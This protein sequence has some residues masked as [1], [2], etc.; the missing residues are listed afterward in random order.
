MAVT[1]IKALA[2]RYTFLGQA[3]QY[4]GVKFVVPEGR[5]NYRCLLC[6]TSG[7]QQRTAHRH[8]GSLNHRTRHAVILQCQQQEY[9]ERIAVKF[10]KNCNAL[11]LP[12]IQ[13]APWRRKMKSILFDLLM[14]LKSFC[15]C[16]LFFAK[17]LRMEAL[18]LLELALWK[19]KI[20]NGITFSSIQDMREYPTLDIDFNVQRF[21]Y[22]MRVSSGAQVV[23]PL[24]L[25]YLGPVKV[26][27]IPYNIR[28]NFHRRREFEGVAANP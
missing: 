6:A 28:T 25:E 10:M 12:L 15:E 20:A 4:R 16:E 14:G 18:S 1:S 19:A 26:E 24:V 8:F 13:H 17:V 27:D 9:H 2:R 7:I 21:G 5:G 3:N 22:E 23:L 11:V